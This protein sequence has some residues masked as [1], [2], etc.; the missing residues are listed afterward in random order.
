MVLTVTVMAVW[1]SSPEAPSPINEENFR[2]LQ[3]GMTEEQIKEIIGLPDGDHR[4]WQD[5]TGGTDAVAQ[6][7]SLDGRNVKWWIGDSRWFYGAAR[8]L[9]LENV[10]YGFGRIT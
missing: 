8:K 6:F 7:G 2:M 1:F 10:A 5:G 3:V 9:T 4:T